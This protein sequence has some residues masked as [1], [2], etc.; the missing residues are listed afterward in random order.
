MTNRY[1]TELQ[2]IDPICDTRESETTIFGLGDI[3]E[4]SRSVPRYDTL[5]TGKKGSA[6][7]ELN[8]PSGVSIHEDTHQIFVANQFNNRVEIF[9]E[10]GEFL[11][12]LGVGQLPQPYGIAIHGDSIYVSCWSDHTVNKFSMNEM[13]LIRRIGGRGSDN[14]Q[15]NSPLQHT[16]DPI[17]RVFIADWGNNRI[18]IH[19]SDLN[20]IRNIT[21]ESMSSPCDVKVSLDCIYV[22]C[23]LTN[24]CILVFTLEGDMLH[25]LITCGE[26]MDVSWPYFFC[27]DPL[28]N[29]VISDY[30]SHSIRVFSPEGILLHTIGRGGYQPGM[31]SYPRGVAITPNERIVYVSRNELYGLQVFY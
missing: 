15:F 28:N 17:G 6:P 8:T 27:L 21:H 11:Y 31:F 9:S 14:G 13:C 29:L 22:L 18:S 23:T 25:S 10:M 12:Q 16:T 2:V 26:E 30:Q 19:D 24:S 5:A 1:I 7:G 4:V 20:H 3:V